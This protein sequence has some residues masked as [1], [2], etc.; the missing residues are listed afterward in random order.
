MEVAT[1]EAGCLWW[2][3]DSEIQTKLAKYESY[4]DRALA[5]VHIGTDDAIVEGQS[6][7]SKVITL[8]SL[9][10]LSW[11]ESSGSR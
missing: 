9:L 10:F 3:R 7:V 1:V 2:R 11:V 8:L 4:L 5:L 6:I